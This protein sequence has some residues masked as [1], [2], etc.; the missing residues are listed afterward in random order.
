VANW[1]SDNKR[2]RAHRA[3][4][5][6]SRVFAVGIAITA[7]GTAGLATASA[8]RIVSTT[9]TPS[10]GVAGSTALSDTALVFTDSSR[11]VAFSLWSPGTCGTEG[12]TPVFTDSQPV[13][14]SAL[15]NSTLT[16]APFVPRHAGVYEWT[17]EVAVNSDGSIENGPTACTD[18]QVTITAGA[19]QINTTPSNAD[20]GPAGTSITDAAAVTGGVNPTGTVTFEVFGPSNPNCVFGEDNSQTWLQRWTVSLDADGNASVPPPGYTTTKVGTYHWVAIYSGDADN[21]AARSAC[22]SESVTITKATPTI[23]TAASDGG[24]IGTQIHDTAQVSGGDNPTGTVTF[25]LFAPSNPTCAGGE[26]STGAVQTVTVPLGTNGS[27]TSA[28]TPFTTTEVGTYNWIAK[29]SGD[30]DNKSVSTACTDEQVTI[31]KDPTSVTTA[32]SAGGAPGIALHD[33]ARVTGAFLPTGTVTFT[34]HGPAD[35]ACTAA[36]I[37]TSTVALSASGTATSA[38]F[39]GT[40]AAGTYNWVA[41][42]SGDARSAPSKSKCGAE[43]VHLT[44]SGVKGITTPGTG[45]DGSITQV[46]L[47]LELLLGGLGLFLG[48]ELVKRARKA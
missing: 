14:T 46:G 1:F 10:H 11:H 29:Y 5:S 21:L 40:K 43:P 36:P 42:Y 9:P 38:S 25:S 33:T 6:M 30:A 47:G 24:P 44:A 39:S 27:A 8:H 22:G 17:A 16:S 34:L 35:T 37:F 48:G 4:R 13:T 3:R 18:E 20:G 41:A 7:A 19:A 2:E 45:L 31:G 23:T 32:A 28:G 15:T 26:G 12:A